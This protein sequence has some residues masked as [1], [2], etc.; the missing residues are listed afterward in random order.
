MAQNDNIEA[1]YGPS[2]SKKFQFYTY[3]DGKQ[4]FIR[5]NRPVFVWIYKDKSISYIC[6]NKKVFP[7]NDTNSYTAY[8]NS[9]GDSV[10]REI[11][12]PPSTITVTEKDR[13]KGLINRYFVE[14]SLDG[15]IFE[16]DKKKFDLDLTFYK[17][18]KIVWYLDNSTLT[19]K[20]KN[21]EQI[22]KAK[23]EMDGIDKHL[24]PLEFHKEKIEMTKQ[25]KVHEKLSRLKQY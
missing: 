4:I 17:K 18:I 1:V 20:M 14:Y 13:E 9:V 16:I 5:K 8:L 21:M 25:E 10:S 19:M 3:E 6:Q 23:K 12:I 15:S 22:K 2:F 24:D 11:Y 7:Y